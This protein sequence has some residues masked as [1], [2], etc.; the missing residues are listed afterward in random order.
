[1]GLGPKTPVSGTQKENSE[2]DTQAGDLEQIQGP[3]CPLSA[4][5]LQWDKLGFQT[6]TCLAPAQRCWVKDLLT[7]KPLHPCL[8]SRRSLLL[9]CPFHGVIA[10]IGGGIQCG[11]MPRSQCNVTGVSAWVRPETPSDNGLQRQKSD[12]RYSEVQRGDK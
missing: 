11:E 6:K 2:V 7:L 12:D 10:I 1:L 9:S 3:F 4:P 5:S 8:R